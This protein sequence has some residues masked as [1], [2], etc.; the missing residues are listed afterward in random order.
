MKYRVEVSSVARKQLKKSDRRTVAIIVSW[1]EKNL[2]NCENP[3]LYGKALKGNL[4]GL[5]RYRIGDYRIIAQIED[6]K[7]VILLIEI[8]HR[9]NIY[10]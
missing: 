9:K 2:N 6:E 7:L 4:K 3:R 5:W 10:N 1:I 8:G